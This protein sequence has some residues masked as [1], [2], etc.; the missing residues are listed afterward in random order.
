[1]RRI[2]FDSEFKVEIYK[3]RTDAANRL[4]DRCKSV[5]GLDSRL[6][7]DAWD[8]FTVDAFAQIP[9]HPCFR[10]SDPKA[11][12][13][14]KEYNLQ[15]KLECIRR[16]LP[17]FKDKA[18]FVTGEAKKSNERLIELLESWKCD[19]PPGT[20]IKMPLSKSDICL[21]VP[22]A[23]EPIML[24][25]PP[26][27]RKFAKRP[28]TTSRKLLPPPKKQCT[29]VGELSQPAGVG[30]FSADELNEHSMPSEFDFSN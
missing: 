11:K 26:T 22:E 20:C 25:L 24:P 18:A 6:W 29:G 1:M 16:F 15:Y 23:P 10:Y 3:S 7:K 17:K 13:K 28:R 12:E 5:N 2:M 4:K 9:K 27:Y 19:L 8:R 14:R 21:Q 30:V